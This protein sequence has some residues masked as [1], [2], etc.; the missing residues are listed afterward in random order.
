MIGV[1]IKLGLEQVMA[2]MIHC[3]QDCQIFLL[4]DSE[5]LIPIAKWFANEGEWM[6][7]LL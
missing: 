6:T 4:V 3:Q 2:P 1:N 5:A 7:I